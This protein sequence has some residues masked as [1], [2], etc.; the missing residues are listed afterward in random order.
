MNNLAKKLLQQAIDKANNLVIIGGAGTS[1]DCGIP[2]FRGE[3]GR[4]N[5]DS[6]VNPEKILSQEYYLS[7]PKGFFTYYRNNMIFDWAKP[8]SFH[9]KL[10]KLEEIGKLKAIITQNIDGLHQKAGSK[11][12]IELH[13]SSAHNYCRKCG[14]DY[15]EQFMKEMIGIPYCDCGGVVKPDVTLYGEHIKTKE[16]NEA[17]EYITKAD[18]LLITGTS[19]TVYPATSLID[20]FSGRYIII[21]NKTETNKDNK[22]NLIINDSVTKVFEEIDI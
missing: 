10:V 16:F 20:Y 13:G 6:E 1:T 3:N 15:P 11:N 2:D 18:T 5:V 4:Y 22:A 14:K 7:N 8:N 12:V 19:L 21:I 9:Y 17:K